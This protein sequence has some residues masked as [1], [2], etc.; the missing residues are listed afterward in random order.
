MLIALDWL[1]KIKWKFLKLPY[2]ISF[3]NNKKKPSPKIWKKFVKFNDFC[4]KSMIYIW[5]LKL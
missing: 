3:L 5:N 2:K 4:P 1:L